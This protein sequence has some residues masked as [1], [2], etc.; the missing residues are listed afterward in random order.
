MTGVTGVICKDNNLGLQK[1]VATL[2]PPLVGGGASI[3]NQ[4]IL[5]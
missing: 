5:S 2:P 4:E 3:Y 1:V